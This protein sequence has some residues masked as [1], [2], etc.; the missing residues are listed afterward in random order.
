MQR[1]PQQRKRLQVRLAQMKKQRTGEAHREAVE[2]AGGKRAARKIQCTLDQA[3]AMLQ[4]VGLNENQIDE[5]TSEECTQ[6]RRNEVM[7]EFYENT[8]SRPELAPP[9]DT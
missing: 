4:K 8:S 6:E 3:K 9:L 2:A 5:L 7:R 1:N